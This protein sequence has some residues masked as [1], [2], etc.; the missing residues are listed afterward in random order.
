[1][2]T[3]FGSYL[4]HQ[5]LL[6]FYAKNIYYF[7]FTFLDGKKNF[8]IDCLKYNTILN[9]IKILS[10]FFW[11]DLIIVY[12]LILTSWVLELKPVAISFQGLPERLRSE[13]EPVSS[14]HFLVEE[15]HFGDTPDNLAL[16]ICFL[17]QIFSRTTIY[18]FYGLDTF[19]SPIFCQIKHLLR[20]S[21]ELESVKIA[22]VAKTFG[23]PEFLNF[24]TE[25]Y[26]ISEIFKNIYLIF[27]DF[28][29]LKVPVVKQCI[30]AALYTNRPIIAKKCFGKVKSTDCKRLAF[31]KAIYRSR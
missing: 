9:I 7:N 24:C 14:Y 22:I 29:C 10:F 31:N 12:L 13:T 16:S 26:R 4:D 3:D 6:I 15:P 17:S 2:I 25:L 21:E 20:P 8:K 5:F 11:R 18:H 19:F 30:V 27:N 23:L 28:S 1:M